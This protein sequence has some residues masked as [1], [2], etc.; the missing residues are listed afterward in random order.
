M[1]GL[2]EMAYLYNK[3]CIYAVKL[4][5]YLV[6]NS[7]TYSCN[8]FSSPYTSTAWN[9]AAAEDYLAAKGAYT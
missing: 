4:R 1:Y 9:P 5:I 6:N 8:V 3:Y 2:T 7:T